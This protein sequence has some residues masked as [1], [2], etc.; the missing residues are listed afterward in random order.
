MDCLKHVGTT[1]WTKERLKMV[2]N[3]DISA[4]LHK[5]PEDSTRTNCF[6][7]I[8]EGCVAVVQCFVLPN[9]TFYVLKRLGIT[10]VRFA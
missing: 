3:T 10:F 2:V 9:S 7:H 4:G 8:L 5:L 1:D 6:V